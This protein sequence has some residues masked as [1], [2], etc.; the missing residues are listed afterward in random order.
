M[1]NLAGNKDC[2]SIL[3]V[4][5][6]E[7]GI[8]VIE[9]SKSTRS[10]VPYGVIG[11]LGGFWFT[12]AWYYWAART[13]KSCRLVLPFEFANPLHEAHSKVVRA[14]GH[15]Y[16]PRPEELYPRRG[17]HLGVDLYHVDTQAGLNALADTLRKW[18]SEVATDVIFDRELGTWRK[19]LGDSSLGASHLKGLL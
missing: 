4:E 19:L 10:E 13:A 6:E 12:R 17:G 9:L 5:L 18:M 2:D 3:R 14:G 8:H 7:A 1:L 16:T 11:L 15:C